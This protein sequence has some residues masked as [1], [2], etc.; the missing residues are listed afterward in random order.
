MQETVR[1]G[2]E[3]A[4]I[5]LLA[6]GTELGPK[7]LQK[8]SST[9]IKRIME[10]ASG[11]GPVDKDSLD[12]L[13]DEFAAQFAQSLGLSTGVDQVRNLVERAFSPGELDTMLA[14]GKP[15]AAGKSVWQRFE[16]GSE[17][18]L[19][20]YFLDEHPQ[21]VAVILSRL[22]DSLAANC[23]AMLPG[24]LRGS[25]A[26]RLLKMLPLTDDVERL[27]QER[28]ER[29]LLAQS[30]AGLEDEGR[31]RLASLLNKVDRDVSEGV[32]QALTASR[33]EDARRLRKMIFSFEDIS[34]LDQPSRL[35]LFDKLQT[36]EIVAALRGMPEGFKETALSSLGARA[37]RMV[38]AE[39]AGDNAQVS[40]EGL[41]ARRTIAGMVLAMAARGELALPEAEAG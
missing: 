22:D 24:D 2:T 19:V 14:G 1:T 28:L 15:V 8:F 26:Q 40:K 29:D 9:D 31:Q 23:L 21:T 20:S 13:V 30:A 32:V 18:A 7:V 6:L 17:E 33:P 5:V 4:A 37:R 25:V 16:T 27:L 35:A 11:I 39:L 12:L 10:K 34:K 41:A 38:E 36:E 3:K